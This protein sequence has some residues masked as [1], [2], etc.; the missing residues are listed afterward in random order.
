MKQQIITALAVCTA[1]ACFAEKRP[2]II[3]LMS[4]D[5]SSYTLGCY[6]N[7]DVKT[8]N[9]DRLA[10]DG[11]AFDNHYDT[12]AICMASRATVMTGMYEYKHGTNFKHGDML[13]GIWKKTYPILLREAGYLTAFAG[14][15]G[16]ELRETPDGPQLELPGDDFDRWGGG[17]GQTF[18]ET[19]KNESMAD[20]AK[21]YPH[22]TLSYGA[23]GRDFIRDAANAGK[24]F[25]L[26]IS[27][28]APHKPETPDPKFDDVYAGKT[29]KKPENYG[30]EN[31][32]HFSKQSK[33]GRQY[34]RFEEW[35][36]SDR[37]DEVM[38]IYHQQIYA[39]DVAVGMIREAL[40]EQGVADNTV[41]IYT[42]D[43]GFFCGSHGLGSKVL[44]YE[45]ATRVPM[46]IYDPRHPN[47]GKQL[48]SDAL[49]GNIDFAPTLLKLAGLPIPGNMDGKDLM[50]LYENPQ[51]S[52]HESLALMNVYNQENSLSTR[53]LATVTKDMKYVFWSYAADGF[54]EAEE[55][56][57]LD[58]DPLELTNQAG[59]PEYNSTLKQMR[60]IYDSYLEHWKSE[61]VPYNNY[62]P[63]GTIFDRSIDWAEKEPVVE[64]LKKKTK[65]K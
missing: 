11:M 55:L 41:I 1:W 23:F 2:N 8:P 3:Y 35:G 27:F 5:Q 9:I 64:K 20:Y 30:R 6:G 63:Y 52:I 62:Q 42:S 37:Y 45:E 50:P 25:C 60:K 26:S 19:E 56:Y 32:E 12:T 36:Y 59:N 29:F 17:P 43:N 7:E 13:S 22:S 51:A 28:K 47:S 15:L 57:H 4:D 10:A 54:E 61:G 18:Y 46:I 14:K 39:I 40:E 58:K 24:P 16:F 65:K 49:T 34:P 48:R 31:G 38:A 44:P 21:E 53:F 33:S